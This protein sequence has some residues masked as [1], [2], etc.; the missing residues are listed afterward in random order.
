MRYAHSRFNERS[1]H[2]GQEFKLYCNNT[3]DILHIHHKQTSFTRNNEGK[4]NPEN[5][6]YDLLCKC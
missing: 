3:K 2:T 5:V 4:P 6:Y 1:V